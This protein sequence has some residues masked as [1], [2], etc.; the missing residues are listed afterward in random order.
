VRQCDVVGVDGAPVDRLP[1]LRS[2][3]QAARGAQRVALEVVRFGGDRASLI[4][5]QVELAAQAA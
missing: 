1:V 4:E 3:R 5:V 2:V